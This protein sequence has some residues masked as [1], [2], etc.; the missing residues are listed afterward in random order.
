M[1]RLRDIGERPLLSWI[2]DAAVLE[3]F[4]LELVAGVEDLVPTPLVV[5]AGG[6]R[7]DAAVVNIGRGDQRL[8]RRHA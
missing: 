6:E 5:A 7:V 2:G 4:P 8:E 1:T 3:R